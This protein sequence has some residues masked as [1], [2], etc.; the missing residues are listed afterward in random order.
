MATPKNPKPKQS[1]IIFVD[2]EPKAA[3]DGMIQL[4]LYEELAYR[5]IIDLIYTTGNNLIDDDKKMGWMT[6]VG[7][8]WLKIKPV[9]LADGKI[10]IE[11]GRIRNKK[12]DFKCEQIE[13][14]KSQCSGAGK[15]GAESRKALKDKET[16]PTPVDKSLPKTPPIPSTEAPTGGQPTYLPTDLQGSKKKDT[17][18][19]VQKAPPQKPKTKPQT[20]G[21]R[22]PEDWEPSEDMRLW[23]W[24][25]KIDEQLIEFQTKRFK[26]FWIAKAGVGG[27]K[28]SWN[29]TWQNWIMDEQAKVNAK[30]DQKNPGGF[31]G[32][33][34]D[35]VR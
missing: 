35:M 23:A 1:G 27:V 11:G 12:C 13:Q 15:L 34:K 25:E 26:N 19:G 5:R 22:L 14:K 6:K 18:G 17:Q 28:R 32:M 21:K 31:A 16:P 30:M 4:D 7:K 3:L 24:R 10:Y 33:V 9:L 20:N 29:R 2:W 8:R